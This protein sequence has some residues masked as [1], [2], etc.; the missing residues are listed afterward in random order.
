MSKVERKEYKETK[1]MRT[2]SPTR[3]G[4]ST[5]NVT[6]FDNSLDNLLEDLQ[7]TVPRSKGISN[8]SSTMT[9]YRETSRSANSSDHARSSSMT[10]VKPSNP[11]TEYS[12][13]DSYLYTA[14]DGSQH[15]KTVKHESY[16]YKST[17]DVHQPEKSRMQNNINQLDSLLDDLQQVKQSGGYNNNNNNNNNNLT[18]ETEYHKSKVVSG[19]RIVEKDVYQPRTVE[20]DGSA[21]KEIYQHS[22]GTY[23]DIKRTA[24][25][26]PIRSNTSTLSKQMKVSNV[27]AYPVDIIE[28]TTPDIN[29]EILASL[30][31]ELLPT[32]NTKVTTTIK[33]YT[34]E[35][36]G[37]GTADSDKYVYSPN[38]SVTTPSK[39]F[40]YNKYENNSLSRN[41]Q[42]ENRYVPPPSPT[43]G[44][45]Q[46]IKETVTT[47][48]YQP[49][50]YPTEPNKHTY[51]YNETTNTRNFS[52]QHYSPS[53]HPH[54]QPQYQHP[55]R[56]TETYII[57]E[58]NTTNRGGDS[59]DQGHLPPV[60]TTIQRFDSL[61]N[62]NARQYPDVEVF[63]PKNPPFP[64]GHHHHQPQQQP[65]PQSQQMYPQNPSPNPEVNVTYKYKSTS[66][67][68]NT[69]RG[70]RP[71]EQ[72]ENAPLLPRKFPTDENGP[73]RKLDELM[74][75]IGQEPPNSPYN[76]GW[77]AHEEE[78]AQQRKIDTLKA[79]S[80]KKEEKKDVPRT[81][82]VTGPPVYYP[83]GHEM[84]AMKEE[85]GG[86]WRAEGAMAK[87]RG[88]YKYEAESKSKS[89][90]SSGA[91]VVPICLPLCCG[92]PCS[93]I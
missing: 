28:T 10:R 40:V 58:T 71:D 93:I 59:P 24:S 57:K 14:P 20:R 38:Q 68:T 41:Y 78:L 50:N 44:D 39:S 6:E 11:I 7:S 81:K 75:N 34:Y 23:G 37:S 26:S 77:H 9:S 8:G 21:S 86:A 62:L 31:P 42:A 72:Y 64:T 90:S 16:S 30:D 1:V 76:A 36:P 84:F 49:K 3:Y 2:M 13:D 56:N 53:S 83:P 61:T 66:N 69:Y 52:D 63:D 73:P 47:R 35:I 60:T 29:P 17:G 80:E 48:N 27:Q 88:M 92:L 85:G 18:A 70:Q 67:T 5:H 87:E 65:H 25:P 55:P 45:R 32:G 51:I 74:A 89:K 43:G 19:K 33:T 12:T 4:G 54:Q 79:Q 91:A 22:E 15:V 46:V 82:N